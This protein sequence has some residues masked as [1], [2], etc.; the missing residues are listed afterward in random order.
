MNRLLNGEVKVRNP[1]NKMQVTSVSL[2]PE[3]V[4][5]IVFWTKNPETFIQY[6]T[7]IDSLNI[8]YYFLFT[9]NY[10]GNDYEVNLPDKDKLI[11]IFQKLSSLISKEK[12]IWRYDPIIIDKNY[13]VNYHLEHFEKLCSDL[14]KYTKQCITSFI[15]M[16]NKCKKNLIDYNINILKEEDQ[17]QIL[18]EM[19]TIAS[20]YN[21]QL[22][23]CASEYSFKQI[24]VRPAKCIDADLVQKISGKEIKATKD[25]FQ[26]PN[27]NC[28]RSIDIGAYNTCQHLCRYCYANY[29]IEKVMQNLEVIND[30]NSYLL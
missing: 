25:N 26:R 29:S 19:K 23:I 30:D 21:I 8:H 15:T 27:C 20:K 22:S 1:F 12:V 28:D 14:G 3:N 10:Y 6:L 11:S 9:L 13:S 16:Y 24:G 5:C 18:H 17:C 4:D 7:Q 2:K